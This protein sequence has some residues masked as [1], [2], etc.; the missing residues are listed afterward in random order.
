MTNIPNPKQTPP[1]LNSK[2]EEN[3]ANLNRLKA[4]ISTLI[5]SLSSNYHQILF[6]PLQRIFREKTMHEIE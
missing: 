1:N 6:C 2:R 3:N 5:I 4:L